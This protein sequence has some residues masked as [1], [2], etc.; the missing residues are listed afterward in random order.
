MNDLAITNIS[1]LWGYALA[2]T[3][4]RLGVR[5]AVVSPGSRST[6]IL[7]ALAHCPVIETIPLLDERGAAF[8]ALGLARQSNRPVVL[9]CTSGTAAAN[10]LPA[11]I[12]A[13]ESG[14]PLLVLTADRPPEL[15]QC[16]A[17]QAIDQ[18]KLYGSYVTSYIELPVPEATASCIRHL[19]ETLAHA[20]RRTM[21]PYKGPAHIN[22]PL[23]EPLA[24]QPGKSLALDF[25]PDALL[26]GFASQRYDAPLPAIENLALPPS[27]KRGL[28]V[29]GTVMA[30]NDAQARTALWKLAA[31]SGWPVLC[32][33]LGP[34]RAGETQGNVVRI[35][36]YDTILSGKAAREAL[37][38]DMV[39]QIGPLPTSKAL[40]EFLSKLDRPTIVAATTPENIDPL[41]VRA[42]EIQIAPENIDLIPL[43]AATDDAYAKA[44]ADLEQTT[45]AKLDAT[46]D[47]CG[48]LF[49]GQIVREIYRTLS[50]D[51][52][53]SLANSMSVRDAET[54]ADSGHASFRIF[55]SRGA[56]GI[57]GTLAAA[58]GA[59][60]KGKGVLL[61]GDLAL[62][63][64]AG[65]LMSARQFKGSLTIVLT[66]NSGGGIFE[67]LPVASINDPAFETYFATPQ[68][69]NIHALATAYGA[70]YEKIA[71]IADLHKR[72]TNLPE[73]G[74]S[75]LH[76]KTDRKRDT[77][78]RA[79]LAK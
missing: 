26:S 11:I 10:Y 46:L 18:V 37:A 44:W 13:H 27:V 65:S 28:I 15:R 50:A 3:L 63:Y 79:S 19:R 39:L 34:W 74:V 31:K 62:L 22:C 66:D 25:D 24:P 47:N 61:T 58:F 49:E 71:T 52:R 53:L 59:S 17:G 75:I 36:A 40:R 42:Q 9:A 5:Q 43:P 12:E 77:A 1:S 54:F 6:P 8:F 68:S 16:A 72:L 51:A 73:S 57:D 55:F 35:T 38:P 60:H 21:L 56:N 76:L 2:E 45:R 41:H 70:V 78:F 33:A 23:R 67:K 29:A 20:L 14:A 48:F 32:E 4:A 64:D 7:W 69:V 30:E